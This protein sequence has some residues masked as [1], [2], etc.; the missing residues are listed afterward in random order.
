MMTATQ[1]RMHLE[2]LGLTQNSAAILLDIGERSS[3]RYAADGNPPLA[4]ELLLR[5]MVERKV[6]PDE[7]FALADRKPPKRGWGD[8]R[9]TA[10]E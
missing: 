7:A 2:V 5:V 6:S 4:I 3:R 9:F 1:Y 10:G 8:A